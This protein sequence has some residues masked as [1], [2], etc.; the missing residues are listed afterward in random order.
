MF[1]DVSKHPEAHFG[2]A[3][4]LFEPYGYTVRRIIF[5]MPIGIA[6]GALIGYVLALVV[7]WGGQ[8]GLMVGYTAILLAVAPRRGLVVSESQVVECCSCRMLR[9][10]PDSRWNR[11]L[12]RIQEVVAWHLSDHGCHQQVTLV[13]AG[14]REIRFRFDA[15]AS[16]VARL[17][18][19]LASVVGDPLA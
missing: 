18:H 9:P 4:V 6:V 5:S 16:T 17:K 1:N 13:L 8:F 15:P 3:I 12:V 7:S 2:S 14:Q 10:I 11:V 19:L